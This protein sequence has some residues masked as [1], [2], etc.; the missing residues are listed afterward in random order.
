MTLPLPDPNQSA[1]NGRPPAKLSAVEKVVRV[2]AALTDHRGVSEISR[3]TDI[4]TSSVHR[5]VSELVE[6][7]WARVD[8]G[9]GYLPGAALMALAGWASSRSGFPVIAR[10]ILEKLRD[11]TTHTIHLGLRMGDVAVYVDKLDGFRSYAMRSRVGLAVPM[12]STAIGKAILASMPESE[13]LALLD[14][15]GL[16]PVT[17]Y[18]ITDAETLIGELQTAARVGYALDKEENEV[19]TQ[20]VAAAVRDFSGVPIG[21]L[22]VS[23][24]AFDL[25][26]RGIRK[27]APMVAEAA[28]TL[29]KMLGHS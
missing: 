13:M 26:D 18:T 16:P 9:R 29:S 25:D 12:H 6:L 15:T 17:P 7:G 10:P 14:R 23:G 5:I 20:C 8:G 28:R 22:S 4:P 1:R 19:H 3:A 24:M 11:A 2:V 27:I 21:A